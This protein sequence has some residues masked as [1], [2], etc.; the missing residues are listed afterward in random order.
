MDNKKCVSVEEQQREI[1]KW[2]KAQ[3]KILFGRVH[4]GQFQNI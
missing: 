3:K 2:N 1:F 4:Q